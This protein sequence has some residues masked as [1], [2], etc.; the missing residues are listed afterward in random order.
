MARG[1]LEIQP[2]L[3]LPAHELVES[4]SRSRGPGGQNVNKVS[5]RVSLRWNLLRSTALSASQRARLVERLGARLT[6]AGEIL[7]HADATRS[8]ERN[9]TLARER[10]AELV[11][12]ALARP[13]A[14][15]PTRVG[16]RAR[17]RRLASKQRQSE[18]KRGRRPPHDDPA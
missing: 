6:A 13:R 17:A 5:T 1:D 11:R 8:Q 10:L 15:I 16:P 14:R 9:R 18:R 7:V 3:I 2:S 12:A 4:A